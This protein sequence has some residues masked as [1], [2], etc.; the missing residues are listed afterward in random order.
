MEGA[1]W[2]SCLAAFIREVNKKKSARLT[3]DRI[4]EFVSRQ[5]VALNGDW[6]DAALICGSGNANARLYYYA[7]DRR[8]LQRVWGVVWEGIGKGLGSDVKVRELPRPTSQLGFGSRGCPAVDGVKA[9]VQ[10]LVEQCVKKLRGRRSERRTLLVHN[11]LTTYVCMMVLWHTGVRA[12]AEPIELS[13]YDA[14][15]GMLAISDKDTD[16]YY[17]SRIAWLPDLVQKQLAAYQAHLSA[18]RIE[19]PKLP[20]PKRDALFFID[21]QMRVVPVRPKTLKQALPNDY[22][23]RLNAPRHYLRTMLRELGAHAQVVDALL[24]H[25]ASGQE[26][27]GAHSC[28]SPSR[29]RTDAG[30]ALTKLSQLAGWKLLRGLSA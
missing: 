2:S 26:P 4:A 6:A 22:P 20:I 7:P 27:Y 29:L 23:Y 1:H 28:F 15:T 8:H 24:G 21:E 9:V 14:T 17:S 18:L 25:G 16:G 11:A 10:T 5:V 12:V 3:P 30:P 13:L 19:L